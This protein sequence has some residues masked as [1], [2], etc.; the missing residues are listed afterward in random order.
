MLGIDTNV[1]I[2]YLVRDDQVQYDS[3]RRL[4]DRKVRK[5]E[6]VL[7][8]LLVLLETE[9]VLRSRYELAKADLIATF[10]ALLDTADLTVEDEP[11]VE[12]AI[13][14]WK[15]STVDFADCL[16]EARNRRLGCQA[17]ATFDSRAQKLRGFISVG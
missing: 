3:A 11:S 6:P 16:I 4:I 1:L 15:D 9:W 2:R 5:G 10:S 8:S 17:T 7:L 14:F 13:Y 12:S